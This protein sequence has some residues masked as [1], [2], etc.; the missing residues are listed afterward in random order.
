[1][2]KLSLNLF[3]AAVLTMGV[4]GAASAADFGA[5]FGGGAAGFISGGIQQ[6]G[7]FASGSGWGSAESQSFGGVST[8]FGASNEWGRTQQA[9]TVDGITGSTNSRFQTGNAGVTT[10]SRFGATGWSDGAASF[11]AGA[12]GFSGHLVGGLTGTAFGSFGNNIFGR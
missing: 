8:T 1:M 12:T 5:N 11:S 4:V 7:A 2:R 9:G 3:T 10:E 6:G